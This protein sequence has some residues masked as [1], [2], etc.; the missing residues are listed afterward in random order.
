MISGLRYRDLFRDH[1]FSG[2]YAADVLTL[3]GTYM[4]RFAVAA[5]VLDRTGSVAMTAGVFAA[6]Y[7]PHVF[8]PWLATLADIFPT[9]GLMVLADISRAAIALVLVIPDVPYWLILV[10]LFTIETIQIPFGASRLATLADVLTKEEF[11]VGNALVAATRQAL[12]VLS[13]AIGGVIVYAVDPEPALYVNAA[14]FLVSALLIQAFVRARPVAWHRLDERPSI[15]TGT[16]DGLAFIR[17]APHMT[18]WFSLLAVGPGMVVVAEA[19]ALPWAHQLGWD[20][21]VAALMMSAIALGGV[22]G[23]VVFGRA[24][25]EQQFALVYPLAYSAAGIVALAGLA[26]WLTHSPV[27]VMVVLFFSG[28]SLCYLVAIQTK[29]AATIPREARGRIFGLGN[30]VMQLSQGSAIL[31]AGLVGEGV[32]I[33]WVLIGLGC[34]GF[35]A[36]SLIYLGDRSRTRVHADAHA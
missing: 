34:I 21:R 6:S 31:I 33:G 2:M 9:K 8:G 36:I 30:T 11:P 5:L 32:R 1:E 10:V 15:W 23:L 19:L 7:L 16:K 14:S 22:A 28:A 18:A 35:V 27:P 24:R 12:Q 29:V 20:E 17:D 13:F 26:G 3:L 4:G 25:A